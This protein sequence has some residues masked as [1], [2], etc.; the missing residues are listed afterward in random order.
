MFYHTINPSNLHRVRCYNCT[1]TE[2][3]EKEICIDCLE[4]RCY[5]KECKYEYIHL[6]YSCVLK[7]CYNSRYYFSCNDDETGENYIID[8]IRE[9]DS[10]LKCWYIPQFRMNLEINEKLQSFRLYRRRICDPL[11]RTNYYRYLTIEE[12]E[13][14]KMKKSAKAYIR[15]NYMF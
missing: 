4:Y 12:I 3:E 14:K 11:I 9:W 6:C 1:K 10:E 13:A 8:K 15:T 7:G 2:Y 5:R